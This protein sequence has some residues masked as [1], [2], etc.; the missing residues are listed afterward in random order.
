MVRI[1]GVDT[2]WL[3]VASML[4]AEVRMYT[5]KMKILWVLP[6]SS[7]EPPVPPLVCSPCASASPAA[8]IYNEVDEA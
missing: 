7:A 5:V 6:K 2:D 8:P 3:L 1:P 4:W